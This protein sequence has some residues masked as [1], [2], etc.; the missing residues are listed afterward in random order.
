MA[1]DAAGLQRNH[2]YKTFRINY[3]AKVYTKFVA[4]FYLLSLIVPL[5][6][7]IAFYILS[8]V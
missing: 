6:Y 7:L 3:K 4:Y 1:C 8:V 5:F 2:A